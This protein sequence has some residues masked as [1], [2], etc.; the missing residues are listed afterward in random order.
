MKKIIIVL[1]AGIIISNK[2]VAQH[3]VKTNLLGYTV[4]R[5]SLSY[6][7][8][9][10]ERN[11]INVGIWYQN[12]PF[13]FPD[14]VSFLDYNFTSK[15][16]FMEYRYY[17]Q[18]KAI[19]ANGFW[20]APYV[21]YEKQISK[22]IGFFKALNKIFNN[23]DGISRIDI[24]YIGVGIDGGIK[25]ILKNKFIFGLYAGLGRNPY[26]KISLVDNDGKALGYIDFDSEKHIIFY[27][28]GLNVGYRFL[29]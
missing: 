3:E 22:D 20:I 24:K 15:G 9:F 26:A 23:P 21:K 29:Q 28:F 2:S 6:E 25:L 4:L 11:G 8:M 7:Y 18:K 1:I 13:Y 27:R 16:G 14:I 10:K 12:L 19:P 5:Y 17:F